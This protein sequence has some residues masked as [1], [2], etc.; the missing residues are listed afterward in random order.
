MNHASLFSGAGGFDI[1]SEIMGWNNVFYCE[2]KDELR[3]V[4][5]YYW[6]EARSYS[7]IKSSDFREWN[8][9][10]DVLTG[11][12]P[13]QPYS[14]AGKRKG[15]EDERH[16]WPYMLNAI[17]SIRPRWVVGENVYG[18]VNWNAGMVFDDVCDDL[19]KEGYN[20]QAFIVPA[21]GVG[22]PHRRYRVFFIAYSG[23]IKSNISV[24]QRRQDKKKSVDFNW[25]SQN[26]FTTNTE[27]KRSYG[28]SVGSNGSITNAHS[29]RRRKSKCKGSSEQFDAN[30]QTRGNV[31]NT[32]SARRQEQHLAKITS[33]EKYCSRVSAGF[34]RNFPSESPVLGRGN[35]IPPQLDGLTVAAWRRISIEAFGN[36]VVPQVVLPFFKAIDAYENQ[37]VSKY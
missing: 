33:W 32:Y 3:H 7:D 22:A 35:G 24:Q 19:E 14:L 15:N 2:I 10:I 37:F 4:L 26:G 5:N 9:K 30:D 31:A 12:F 28:L 18:I 25:Q 20:V 16:L 6:P 1:A 29:K 11:G 27:S 34:W 36:A 13:C 21:A 17:R 23:G 8:G